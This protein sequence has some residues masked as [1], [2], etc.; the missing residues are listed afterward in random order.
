MK[1]QENKTLQEYS[2][3]VA[4]FL[5]FIIRNQKSPIKEFLIQLH[6]DTL[7]LFSDLEKN[8]EN[9]SFCED[10]LI[11]QI[12]NC[13]WALL[14]QPSRDFLHDDRQDP[15][16]RFLI[17]YHLKDDA[18]TLASAPQFP[19]NIARAQWCFRATACWEIICLSNK[20]GSSRQ[21]YI[22]IL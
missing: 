22:F 10:D 21:A 11:C 13:I 19:H 6:S 17:S 2:D 14:S 5:I 9:L 4:Y 7:S 8:L 3:F 18:G 20:T 12:H 16:T 1:P 15:F